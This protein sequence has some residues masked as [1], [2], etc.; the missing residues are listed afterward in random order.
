MTFESELAGGRFCIPE[1]ISC[2]KT[3]W[4]PAPRCSHCLGRVRL[5]DGNHTGTV[6]EFSK[7]ENEYF[8][9]VEFGAARIM[10][11]IKHSPK[12]GQK[13]RVCR[14]GIRD[15]DYYFEVE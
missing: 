7:K 6:I 3:V 12:V 5:Q 14:C 1:C 9:M 8:C 4:P 10:A 11:G 13:V 2:K 15:G